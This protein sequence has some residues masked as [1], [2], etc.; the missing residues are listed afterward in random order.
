MT[1]WN[2]QVARI[3][4]KP[5]GASNQPLDISF[6]R[7]SCLDEILTRTPLIQFWTYQVTKKTM[8]W[9]GRRP[10]DLRNWIDYMD[11]VRIRSNF[12]IKTL[13]DRTQT[14]KVSKNE[15]MKV[16]CLT[17]CPSFLFVCYPFKWSSA[18]ERSTPAFFSWEVEKHDLGVRAQVVSVVELVLDTQAKVLIAAQL[19]IWPWCRTPVEGPLKG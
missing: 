3:C 15:P 7:L 1:G 13:N 2:L 4:S 14:E 11:M 17:H 5:P 6:Y 9:P 18:I 19:F 16:Y 12:G 8:F 10:I